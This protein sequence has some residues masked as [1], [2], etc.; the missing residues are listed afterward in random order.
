VL[1]GAFPGRHTTATVLAI[2]ILVWVGFLVPGPAY[3]SDPPDYECQP[4]Q[5]AEE[6][7]W[8]CEGFDPDDPDTPE[9]CQ[10]LPHTGPAETVVWFLIASG[11]LASGVS[12]LR[13]SRE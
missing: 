4:G 1:S 6:N 9:E 3:A 11:A 12:L 10:E 13:Q 7:P 8:C 2:G 5:T